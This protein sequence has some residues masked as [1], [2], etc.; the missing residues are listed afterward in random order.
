MIGDQTA[1]LQAPDLIVPIIGY[2]VWRIDRGTL[3]S[4]HSGMAWHGGRAEAACVPR[5]GHFGRRGRGTQHPEP[6]PWAACSCGIYAFSEPFPRWSFWWPTV[7]GVAVFWGRVEVHNSGIRGQYAQ[8]VALGLPPRP[9]LAE[10]RQVLKIGRRM[11]VPAV[12]VEDLE[13]EAMLHGAPV[14]RSLVPG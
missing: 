2:R 4:R 5:R 10:R 7:P 12:P 6:A 14:P 13:A 3:R 11:G 8:T 9:M 1:E